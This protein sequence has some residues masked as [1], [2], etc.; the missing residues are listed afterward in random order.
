MNYTVTS[1][2]ELVCLLPRAGAHPAVT[3]IPWLWGLSETS[4]LRRWLRKPVRRM[5]RSR[6]MFQHSSLNVHPWATYSWAL[7]LKFTCSSFALILKLESKFISGQILLCQFICFHLIQLSGK[8]LQKSINHRMKERIKKKNKKWKSPGPWPFSCY[9]EMASR[10][11]CL[12]SLLE[13]P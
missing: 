6:M 1:S 5:L 9:W 4:E 12:Q 11:L 10:M 2:E 3:A 13:L 8:V 7:I